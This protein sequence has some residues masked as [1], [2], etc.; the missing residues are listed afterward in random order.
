M[1]TIQLVVIGAGHLGRIH[2]RIAHRQEQINILAIADPSTSARSIVSEE[3]GIATIDDYRTFLREPDRP[4]DAAIVAAPTTAHYSIVRDCIDA[5]I[6][7]LV[8]KPFTRTLAEANDLVQRANEANVILQVG[9]VER[10]NP[11]LAAALPNIVDPKYIVAERCS[12]YPGRSLDVGVVLDLMIHDLDII[13]AL[14]QSPVADVEALGISVLGGYE[15]LATARLVFE[16][17]CVAQVSASRVS[18]EIRRAMQVYS[19]QSF[20]AIDYAA[21][22]ATILRPNRAVLTRQFNAPQLSN[23]E[24]QQLQK[25]LFEDVL[26][27]E[28]IAPPA[29]NAIEQEQ[30]EFFNSVRTGRRPRVD[31]GSGRDA[32]AVAERILLSID[33]HSWDGRLHGSVGPFAIPATT[34]LRPAA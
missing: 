33:T 29:Q 25:K 23:E 5:R 13:L 4:I 3:L 16:N 22:K 19:A 1:K 12:G 21:G 34:S 31:G 26:V 14:V 32:L 24:L 10:F 2:A 30:R 20:T 11:A 28:T 27:R 18:Y 15:D 17:G 8:E 9:H 6:P 7:V